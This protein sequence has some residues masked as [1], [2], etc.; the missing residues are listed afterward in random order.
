[1]QVQMSTG[2]IFTNKMLAA[3]LELSKYFL[4]IYIIYKN[5]LGRTTV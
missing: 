4:K 2:F 1:M 5:P 3:E